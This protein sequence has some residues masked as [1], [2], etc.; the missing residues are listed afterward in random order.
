MKFLALLWH[1]FRELSDEAAYARHLKY[2]GRVHSS[3]EWREF[4]N[5]RYRRKYQ[6]ARCC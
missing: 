5:A 4:S 1:F 2:S 6:N 3:A